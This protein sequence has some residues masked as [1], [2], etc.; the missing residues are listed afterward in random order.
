MNDA[1]DMQMVERDTKL[2]QTGQLNF[3]KEY[4]MRTYG[5]KED[6]LQA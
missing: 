6:E 5:F 4:W 3:S 2:M 1:D